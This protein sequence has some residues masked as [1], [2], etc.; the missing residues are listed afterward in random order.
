MNDRLTAVGQV[1]TVIIVGG[2]KSRNVRVLPKVRA[3]VTLTAILK[4]DAMDAIVD[5]LIQRVL[6][7]LPW[8][9]ARSGTPS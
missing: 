8:T 9:W 2:E 6:L 3:M 1:V 4:M 5:Y 7:D